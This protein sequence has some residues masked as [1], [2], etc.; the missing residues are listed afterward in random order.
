MF[1]VTKL[2]LAGALAQAL[3]HT[4]FA[5]VCAAHTQE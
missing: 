3:D 1:V 2:T 4:P 5:Q